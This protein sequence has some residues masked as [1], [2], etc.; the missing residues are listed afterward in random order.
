MIS[1]EQKQTLALIGVTLLRVQSTE[2]TLKFCM[3]YVLP[4]TPDLTWE[5][6]VN[7]EQY[8]R[9]KTV[10]YLLYELR[11]RVE[12]ILQFEDVLTQF[13]RMRNTFVHNVDEIPGWSLDGDEGIAAAHSF[14]RELLRLDEIVQSVFW[15]LITEWQD[16]NSLHVEVPGMPESGRRF[17]EHINATYKP[18]I[19]A[20]FCEKDCE[21]QPTQ[22]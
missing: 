5:M 15:G 16:E 4:K 21:D 18:L 22:H 17:F 13:L 3:T 10:G 11:K 7:R 12:I 1:A 19:D 20:I 8:L 2:T 9:T 6:L 14:L